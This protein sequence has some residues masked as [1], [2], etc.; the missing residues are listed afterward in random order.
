MIYQQIGN[1][2]EVKVKW[3]KAGKTMDTITIQESDVE[4][5]KQKVL[6]ETERVLQSQK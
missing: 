3:K 6:L 1:A 4:V 5:V 2:Y